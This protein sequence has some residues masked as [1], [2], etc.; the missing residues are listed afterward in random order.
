M[1]KAIYGLKDAPRAWRKRLHEV[2]CGFNSRQL[3]AEP[4]IY[5]KHLRLGRGSGPDSG[6]EPCSRV[7]DVEKEIVKSSNKLPKLELIIS[8]HVDDLKGGATPDVAKKFL[9]YLE[10]HFG[11]CKAEYT[12]FT[13]T[14]IEHEGK[15]DGILC[16]QWTYID[17]L[18][19]L[20]LS[21]YRG[22]P[23]MK[24]QLMI[25]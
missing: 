20:D 22:R 23:R 11:K 5:V 8:A 18:K 9:E 14:R 19:F 25:R 16:H 24:Q 3:Q 12:K 10:S 4:E 13:H 6:L 21:A 15:P 2:L 7:K 17:T 1:L